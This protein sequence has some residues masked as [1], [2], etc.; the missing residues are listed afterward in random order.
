VRLGGN[1]GPSGYSFPANQGLTLSGVLNAPAY[2]IDLSFSF[3]QVSG[4]RRLVDFLNA[5]SDPA[6]Y[7]L[8]GPLNL[9]NITSR[10]SVAFTAQTMARVNLR[11][12]AGGMFAGYVDGV[13]PCA[14]VASTYSARNATGSRGSSWTA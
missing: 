13:L 3:D 9:Y 14:K 4:F 10:P 1:L 2:S 5:T 7:V 6:L 8:N 11:H 12:D